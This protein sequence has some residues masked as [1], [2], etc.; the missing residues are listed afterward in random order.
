MSE[1]SQPLVSVIIPLY[2]QE[3]YFDACVRSI[4]RQSYS[5]LQVIVVDDGSTDRSSQIADEW[6]AKDERLMVVHKQNEGTAFARRD[7]LKKATGEYVVFVD[8]DDF[9]PL[10]AIATLVNLIVIHNVDLVIGSVTR[11]LGGVKNKHYSDD[12]YDFP[13]ARVVKNPELFD[14]HFLGFFGNNTFAPTMWGRIFR[15]SVIDKASE[16][17]ELFSKDVCLAMEDTYF[18]NMLFPYLDSMYRTMETVYIYRC[19]GLTSH[20]NKHYHNVFAYC[21]KR[22][23]MLDER[24]L[25]EHCEPLLNQYADM[26]YHQ[27]FQL[28]EYK[29]ANK[30]EIV[31]FFKE[32]MGKRDIAK[33][34]VEYFSN[35]DTSHMGARLM[36]ACDY[37]GMWKF[38]YN[39][40]ITLHNSWKYRAKQ[41]FMKLIEKLS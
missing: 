5:N 6:A 35:H 40:Y 2:N 25:S 28:L 16:E 34:L 41:M 14:K 30:E 13:V 9:L 23:K 11:K 29:H 33:R 15:K 18:I 21:D 39:R 7:G 17:T 37:E 8:S 27:A 12:A 20:F 1:A 4:C 26:V 22:L 3:R 36:A 38:A 10:N 24:G 32:E 31:A 19:G